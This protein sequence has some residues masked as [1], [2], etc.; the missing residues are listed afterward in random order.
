MKLEETMSSHKPDM[1]PI[2]QDQ[3]W[4]I[5][6]SK[7]LEE[8]DNDEGIPVSIFNVP[9]TLLSIKQ[10]AYV[11]QLVSL[12]PYHHGRLEL[13]EMER[14]KL[15]SARRTQKHFQDVKFQGIVKN[16]EEY[17]GSIRAC[18]HRFLEFHQETLAWMLAI[19]ASFI[20]EFLQTYAVQSDGLLV[21][22]SSKMAHL[23]DYAR[24]KTTHHTILRDIVML[25]NQIP[26]FLLR[27]LHRFYQHENPDEVLTKMLMGFCKDLSPIKIIDDP[28]FKEECLAK[29]HLLELLYHMVAPTQQSIVDLEEHDKKKEHEEAGCCKRAFQSVTKVLCLINLAPVRFVMKILKSKAIL[30]VI[31]LP[32]Q[33]IRLLCHSKSKDSLA[34]LISSAQNV[35]EEVDDVSQKK[36]ESPLIEELKIPS[37]AELSDNGVKFSPTKGGLRT[38]KFNKSSGTFYLPTIYLDENSEVVI[39]NLVAYEALIAPEIMVLT[40]YTELMN[41]IIDTEEDVKLLREAGIIMNRLKSDGEVATLWNGMTKSVKITKVPVLDKA[42]EG[43]NTYYS[44]RWSVKMNTTLKKYVFASWPVLTFL[45]ANLLIFMSAL[46]AFCSMY[47]CSK[48]LSMN[49]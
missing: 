24:R 4:V 14:Y 20:L 33:I 16:F 15:A 12:G 21:R 11:P 5:H 6:V 17:E 18:Y 49:T 25:E 48:V 37:V 30:L 34:D 35:A 44:A 28:H 29:A 1:Q 42:I 19:D 13:F 9:K 10:E 39:R 7:S 32:W 41:G 43:A 23:I 22:S 3:E 8:E 47:S 26:L 45:A 38:I 46:Q 40:R 31:T 27:E 2:S 36:D